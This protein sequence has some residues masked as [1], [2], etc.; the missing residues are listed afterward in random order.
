MAVAEPLVSCGGSLSLGAPIQARDEDNG[1]PVTAQRRLLSVTRVRAN[2]SVGALDTNLR[3]FELLVEP[4]PLVAT[5]RYATRYGRDHAPLGDR[6][7]VHQ[8]RARC[9]RRKKE[10]RGTSL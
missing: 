1:R 9:V 5:A 8:D 10:P 4:W 7:R 6:Q 3:L 2:G